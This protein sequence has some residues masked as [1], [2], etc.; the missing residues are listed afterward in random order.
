MTPNRIIDH[1]FHEDELRNVDQQALERLVEQY[2]YFAAARVLLAQ[3]QFAYTPDF[4]DPVFKAAQLYT[5]TPQYLYQLAS[6]N[7]PTEAAAPAAEPAD[8]W[9]SGEIAVQDAV[10]GQD[11][12]IIDNVEAA[13]DQQP[14]LHSPSLEAEVDEEASALLD[15][16]EAPSPAADSRPA[17]E[18]DPV[19]EDSA[20][21]PEEKIV[22]QTEEDGISAEDQAIL[23]E[24]EAEDRAAA[25]A[26]VADT[27]HIAAPP[28]EVD[29]VVAVDYEAE[30]E[31]I[32][33]DAARNLEVPDDVVAVD[34]EAEEEKVAFDAARNLEVPDDV[35][36]VDYE[37]EE[38]K[39]AF[40]AARNLEVPDDVVAVDYEAEEE[41]VAFDAARNLEVPDDVV[42]VDYDSLRTKASAGYEP[43]IEEEEIEV[44]TGHAPEGPGIAI[45][46]APET[47]HPQEPATYEP[48][49]EEEEVEIPT[50]H[51]PE[52]HGIA[53]PPAPETA[54]PHEPA[55]YEPEIEEEEV[56]IPTGQAP[57]GHGIAIPPAPESEPAEDEAPI[58]IHP[59]DAPAQ[60]TEL[61]FQPLFTEDYFAYKKLKEPTNAESMTAKAAAE[62][63][64]FT[65]W[66]RQIKDNFAGKATKDWYHQQLH[67]LYEDDD[68]EVTERVEAM[69]IQSITLNDD[70]VS[71]TL[72]EIW[73]RQ[74]QPEKAIA[75]YQKL[76]LLNPGKKAYFAQ[77]IKD[78]QNN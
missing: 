52:G 33:F 62:M 18:S 50:G 42:A 34:Y 77:K 41:K 4:Q 57:E 10:N 12:A 29:E 31:K 73:V 68:P 26:L 61:T 36:A 19:V 47:A 55:T 46:P 72:A 44:P 16:L 8:A 23:D 38:E 51:A 66:L 20:L 37:A 43:E 11:Q 30:E 22:L 71:E 53:I 17:W 21:L 70:I 1:I 24:L 60:E 9:Q 3:K 14:A 45:P 15:E 75:V 40:D 5:S 63:R 58:R 76:S 49:I 27:S 78:L 54:H 35:V 25:A 48:E 69:A 64:S 74:N 32:A 7:A 13:A 59:M 39:V 2:P 6:E 56:E 28:M 67:K 65:D